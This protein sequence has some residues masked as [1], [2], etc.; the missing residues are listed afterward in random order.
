MNKLCFA[1]GVNKKIDEVL[2]QQKFN[3]NILISFY[4]YQNFKKY[5]CANEI[6]SIVL[7]S[8]AY[9]AFSCGVTINLTDYIQCCKELQQQFQTK[10]TDIFSLDV[11]GGCKSSFSNK[12]AEKLTL[13]NTEK[14]WKV[15]IKAIPTYHLGDSEDY[16]MFISKNYP[17]IA[18]G[19]MTQLHGKQ[20]FE[21][22]EQCFNRVYP[23]KI[24]GFGCAVVSILEAF[25]FHST[26]A[27]SWQLGPAT[28]G[29]WKSYP[30]LKIGKIN[31]SNISYSC[32]ESEIKYYLRLE[33]KIQTLWKTEMKRLEACI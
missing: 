24:H 22:V 4:F 17:K 25:P 33:Q 23:K 20:K 5:N 32:L 30:N 26:D 3:A 2:F 21:F 8:G 13:R 1:V 18:I 9:S 10:L 19:G 12:K 27:S 7:D 15:G 28:F 31:C 16:L 11:I 6:Q 29:R 14:L